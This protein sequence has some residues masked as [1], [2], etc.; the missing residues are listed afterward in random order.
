MHNV[1]IA[2]APMLSL[3]LVGFVIGRCNVIGPNADEILSRYVFYCSM[4]AF[5]FLSLIERDIIQ[6]SQFDFLVCFA[7]STAVSMAVSAFIAVRALRLTKVEI[8]LFLMS[9][10]YVNSINLGVPLL[11]YTIGDPLPVVIV[12]VFQ[13]LVVSP[14]LIFLMERDKNNATVIGTMRRSLSI[15]VC[16]PI[17][18]ATALGFAGSMTHWRPPVLVEDALALLGQAAI[19]TA[20]FALGLTLSKID[21]HALRGIAHDLQMA[22]PIK[23]L[24]QPMVT[25]VTGY[26]FIDL[27][28]RW[29]I[30]AI[31]VAGLPTAQNVVI[32]AQR[33]RSYVQEAAGIVFFSSLLSLFTILTFLQFFGS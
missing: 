27:E 30:A 11:V 32:F 33:Y 23:L 18:L 26:A 14:F 17:I 29:L 10:S 24:L 5:L 4:P 3:M 22:L 31:L 8:P 13:L 1:F 28:P 6:A 20:L 7:A 21:L 16:N 12:N 15:L 19:P 25:G 2:A 9:T